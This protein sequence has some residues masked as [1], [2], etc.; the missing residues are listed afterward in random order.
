VPVHHSKHL[1]GNF[2]AHLKGALIVFADEAFWAGDKAGEGALKA[3]ITEEYLAIEFKGKD[4]FYVR[5]HV[6]LLVA[7]NHD[8]AVP[9]GLEER[10][11][12]VIDVS[13]ARM[14]DGKYFGAIVAQM[15]N[16]GRE[17]LLHF[18]LNY[19]LE[20]VDLGK[21]PQTD[22]LREQKILSMPPVHKWWYDRLMDSAV[23]STEY[24]WRTPIECH[25]VHEDFVKHSSQTGFSHRA[26]ETELGVTLKKLVPDLQKRRPT[27]NGKRTWCYELPPLE[28]CRAAFD[29]LTRNRN[30]WPEED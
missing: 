6:R 14:Q 19:D 29:R 2:N 21:F 18:L 1:T 11:F 22:A 26:A 7:S 15:E 9:A 17:A 13:E 3:M 25:L 10:R 8:W 16:G 23:L 20:G 4:A 27:I 12:F 5:N 24:T 28:E 30:P